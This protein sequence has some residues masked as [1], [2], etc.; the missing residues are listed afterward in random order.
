MT[1][2]ITGASGSG[3]TTLGKALSARLGWGFLDADQYY[4]IPTHPPFRVKREP[5]L[6][7]RMIM[8]KLAKHES[9]VVSGSV[10]GWGTEVEDFFALIV[11]LYLDASIRVKR[12]LGY[13][14][15]EFLRWAAEYD[16]GP[17]VGRSLA[18]HKA[19]L[20]KRSCTVLHLEGDLSVEERCDLVMGA[21]PVQTE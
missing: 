1:V 19:W 15:P 4:W 11:F 13:A 8:D 17:S 14:D 20:A 2:L 5:H 9:S 12:E 10:M 6:R 21:L 18:K 7:L 16:A 3:T